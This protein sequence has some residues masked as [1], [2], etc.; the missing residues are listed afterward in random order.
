MNKLSPMWAR[1]RD[2]FDIVDANLMEGQERLWVR[3]TLKA[4]APTGES[5]SHLRFM[6]YEGDDENRNIL[7]LQ[8][9]V[10]KS[11]SAEII[12]RMW[13]GLM[14]VRSVT[15]NVTFSVCTYNQGTEEVGTEVVSRCS[16]QAFKVIY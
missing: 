5:P 16:A 6:I 9:E 3:I 10:I 1:F 2:S 4:E 12:A 14:E 15:K 11:P 7:C 13:I 8:D